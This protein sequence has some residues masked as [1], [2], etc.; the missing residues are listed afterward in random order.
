MFESDGCV[1]PNENTLPHPFLDDNG[2]N[3]VYQKDKHEMKVRYKHYCGK[4]WNAGARPSASM[5]LTVGVAT[6][7]LAFASYSS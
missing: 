1:A 4:V 5:F 7:A 3:P 2:I 6:L